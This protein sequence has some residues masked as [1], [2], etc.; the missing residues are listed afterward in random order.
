[1]DDKYSLTNEHNE[2]SGRCADSYA[3]IKYTYANIAYQ[4]W[5][6]KIAA[7]KSA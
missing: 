5:A 6:D 3:G 4:A 1:M 2:F 7:Y